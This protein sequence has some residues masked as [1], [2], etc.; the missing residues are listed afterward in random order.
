M[1]RIIESLSFHRCVY[2]SVSC[3]T[4]YVSILIYLKFIYLYTLILIII[5]YI[6]Y[7]YIS[8][9]ADDM[10]L[11]LLL[12]EFRLYFMLCICSILLRSCQEKA[13][14]IDKEIMQNNQQE[15]KTNL[16]SLSFLSKSLLI[17]FIK[18]IIIFLFKY[19]FVSLRSIVYTH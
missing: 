11:D 9:I 12:Q 5:I 14:K 18:I 19:L 3:C 10:V 16:Q 17:L 8:E 6:Y 7:T 4:N 15:E 2:A 13:K 1:H